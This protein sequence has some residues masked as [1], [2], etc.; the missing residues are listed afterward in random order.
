MR[1][2]SEFYRGR[3]YI[4]NTTV[5]L[6]IP[7]LNKPV[8]PPPKKNPNSQTPDTIV[9]QPPKMKKKILEHINFITETNVH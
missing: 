3:Y 8:H 5:K 7:Y 1:N 6:E 9:K 4:Q 2:S